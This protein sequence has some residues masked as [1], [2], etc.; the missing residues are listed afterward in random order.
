MD[1]PGLPNIDSV[2]VTLDHP[3]RTDLDGMDYTRCA[4]LH[5]WLVTYAW[6]ASGLQLNALLENHTNFFAH[7]GAAAEAIRSR[8]HPSIVSFL[9]VVMIPPVPDGHDGRPEFFWW[10]WQ[11]NVPDYFFD[12]V[13][14]DIHDEPADTFIVLYGGG[15]GGAAG[16]GTFY[17]HRHHRVAVFG[18]M[19]DHDYAM[20][21]ERHPELWNPLETVLSTWIGMIQIGKIFAGP[22]EARALYDSEKF[23]P[24][25]W[26][27]YSE[28]QV[29]S[30]LKAWDRLC[31]AIEEK[32]PP[33]ASPSAT[34]LPPD[35]EP[36]LVPEDALAAAHV[37]NPSFAYSFLSRARRP[38]SFRRLAPGLLL[39]PT[40]PAAF[41][42]TQPFTPL[43][44]NT[45]TNPDGTISMPDPSGIILPEAG[46]KIHP[47]PPVL[48]FPAAPDRSESCWRPGPGTAPHVDVSTTS[49]ES[50]P[51]FHWY[52]DDH[53]GPGVRPPSVL[54]AGLYLEG[55]DRLAYDIAEEGFR[56]LLPKCRLLEVFGQDWHVLGAMPQQRVLGIEDGNGPRK[57][58]GSL[59]DIRKGELFQH[60]Y[61]PFGGEYHR[62]QRLERV[63]ELWAGLVERGVW[64]VG[65]EGVEGGLEVF[66]H[67]T[68]EG[69]D[70]REY[71]IP[72]SW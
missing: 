72:P 21:V 23:G 17:H 12:D 70:W 1:I 47:I 15:M 20:P 40:E 55:V 53:L 30:C 63:L 27:P 50:N 62:A 48:L 59:A 28:A 10:A 22:K 46:Y 66:V 3:A 56:L 11:L 2:L 42:Y 37:R 31:Q 64:K 9:E 36:V 60:G 58:D 34:L 26:R 38:L 8:L 43:L 16:D 24:W 51:F 65:R 7:Y 61:K 67:G 4:A 69:W 5:N 13:T 44:A 25:E 45:T 54:R 32:L 33:T 35:T 71:I 52:Y 39:P 29:A 19:W 6:L 18:H 57:S 49:A 14:A 41:A 68:G